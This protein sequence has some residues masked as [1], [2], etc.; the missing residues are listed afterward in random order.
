MKKTKLLLLSVLCAVSAHAQL[1]GEGYYRIQNVNSARYISPSD[2]YGYYGGGTMVDVSCLK[3]IEEAEVVSDPGSVIYIKDGNAGGYNLISQGYETYPV[4]ERDLS[5]WDNGDGTYKAYVTENG[6][7]LYLFD[8]NGQCT[9]GKN[10]SL[11][12][13]D[14][15][16]IPVNAKEASFFG[17]APKIA[18]ADSYYQ[19]FYACFPFTIA[20]DGLRAFTIEEVNEAAAK[21][22]IAEVT[23]EVA[24]ATP[25][26]FKSASQEPADNILDIDGEPALLEA[27]G[28]SDAHK[29]TGENTLGA[30]GVFFN[31]D[32]RGNHRNC[33]EY[34][35]VTMRIL[36]TDDA[37]NLA[38]VKANMTTVPANSVFIRVNEGAPDVLLVVEQNGDS[39]ILVGD[40]TGD[41]QVSILDY[42]MISNMILGKIPA[43]PA[44]DLNGDG[45]VNVADAV[46]LASLI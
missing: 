28:Y 24:P 38:F 44:A 18:V 19:S 27:S 21:V 30:L 29:E 6:V 13:S 37:G 11:E 4:F 31:N 16:I 45:E 25:I 42:V 32:V 43:T 10:T 20:S 35:P 15:K 1:N 22:V 41:G 9:T 39:P 23:G 40:L 12:G 7:T 8:L 3:T 46:I 26:I 5:I 33:V 14:W 17:V 34:D 2:N 36:G